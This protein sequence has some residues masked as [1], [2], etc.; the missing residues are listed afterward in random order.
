AGMGIFR[1]EGGAESVYP[2][3]R[4][5]IAFDGEL[6]ADRQVRFFTKEVFAVIDFP[7]FAD[8]EVLQIERRYAEHFARAFGVIRGDDG[9]MNPKELPLMKEAVNGLRERVPHPS[10]RATNV[11][12]NT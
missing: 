10:H 6:A 4:H 8:W 1:T 7:V 9:R 3:E 12:A 5:G 2:R 11:G